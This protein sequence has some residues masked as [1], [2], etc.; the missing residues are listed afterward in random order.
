MTAASMAGKM[1][2][3]D[4][5]QGVPQPSP[6]TPNYKYKILG[7]E[8]E[9]DEFLRGAVKDAE[10]EEKVRSLYTK[11]N[12]LEHMKGQYLKTRETL[13]SKDK[14]LGSISSQLQEIAQ[15]RDKK[16]FGNVFKGLNI[17]P[18][19]VLEWAVQHAERMQ[20]PPEQ[21]Q[22]YEA[23]ESAQDQLR[24]VQQQNQWLQ[25]QYNS[26]VA[27]TRQMELNQSMADSQISEFANTY[28]Q[29]TGQEG[30]F[31][32]EVVR[33]GALHYQMTGQDLPP[34]EVVKQTLFALGWQGQQGQNHGSN[35]TQMP[36]QASGR[37]PIIP[38]VAGKSASPVRKSPKS[39][40]EMRALAKSM[41]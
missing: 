38:H 15:Y 9:F 16:D 5:Q 30:A 6:Y 40:D 2:L 17:K 22:L 35:V 11:A 29:R 1:T 18:D 14:E 21:R 34:A 39:L 41:G 26:Q 4:G 20:L 36:R 25:E 32:M 19:D 24:Q 27:N 31:Q 23:Q 7:K 12:G 13:Q 3:V 10:T 33:R 8:Q 37:P 28:D